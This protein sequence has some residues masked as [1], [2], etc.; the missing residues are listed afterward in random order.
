MRAGFP[1]RR[2]P[3]FTPA[4]LGLPFEETVV[5]SD[6]GDLPAWFIP[7]RGGAPGP[8]VVLVHGWESARD[9][10]LPTAQFLHAAGFHCLTFDVRGNGANPAEMLPISAGEFGAD[11]TAA[12]AALLARPEVTAGGDPRPLDG[13]R[14]A[15]SSPP[16]R[17]RASPRSSASRRRPIPAGWSARPSAWPG[18]RSPD[19]SPRRSPG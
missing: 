5:R 9:R 8:G 18:C 19:R 7:A 13:R 1:R 11:A 12:F 16:Q 10:T 6:S 14:R 3:R 2:P 15:R 17:I 4:D